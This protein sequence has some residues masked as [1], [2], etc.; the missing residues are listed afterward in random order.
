[1]VRNR[2]GT[3]SLADSDTS[4]KHW[5]M[6]SWLEIGVDECFCDDP[7]EPNNEQGEGYKQEEV[8]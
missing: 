7:Y 2:V 8:G 5:T 4:L 6:A 1:M 3:E